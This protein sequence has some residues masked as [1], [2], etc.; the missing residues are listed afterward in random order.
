[1]GLGGFALGCSPSLHVAGEECLVQITQE[2]I[3]VPGFATDSTIAH[4]HLL[5]GPAS[6]WTLTEF[7][8]HGGLLS[9]TYLVY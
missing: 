8:W 3:F 9:T 4:L 6:L 7:L 2:L 5:P 1:M